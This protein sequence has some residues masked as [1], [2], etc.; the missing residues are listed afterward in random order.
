MACSGKS[1]NPPPARPT[2][3]GTLRVAVSTGRGI[4][5]L[6]PHFTYYNYVDAARVLNLYDGLV[7]F[8]PDG[9]P[10]LDLAEELTPDAA[11]TTWTLRIRDGVTFHNGATLTADDV[12]FSIRRAANVRSVHAPSYEFIDLPAIRK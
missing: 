6:D 9:K 4:E 5:S 12:M 8:A 2:R 7:R 1:G 3:G 11:G 10:R